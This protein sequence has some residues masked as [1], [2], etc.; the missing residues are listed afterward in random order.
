MI[1]RIDSNSQ[2]HRDVQEKLGCGNRPV[3]ALRAN[4]EHI[5]DVISAR[6]RAEVVLQK[7]ANELPLL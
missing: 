6:E 1:Y 7:L 3:T 5:V 2:T 4:E